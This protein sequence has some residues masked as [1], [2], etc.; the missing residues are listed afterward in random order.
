MGVEPRLKFSSDSLDRQGSNLVT[1][2]CQYSFNS[3]ETLFTFYT[4]GLYSL[5]DGVYN[6][7]II[8]IF[9]EALILVLGLL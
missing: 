1:I 9:S 5:D 3:S 4:G 8:Q 6:L 2:G 7:H